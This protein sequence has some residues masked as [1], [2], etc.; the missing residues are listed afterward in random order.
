MIKFEERAFRVH[1][2]RGSLQQ[3]A[4]PIADL[5]NLRAEEVLFPSHVGGGL[6]KIVPVPLQRAYRRVHV[7]YEILGQRESLTRASL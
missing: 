3:V 4:A 5:A 1:E 6:C 7:R 2:D